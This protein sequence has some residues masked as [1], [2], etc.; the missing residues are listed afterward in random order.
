MPSCIYLNV[1]AVWI[2]FGELRAQSVSCVRLS[3]T[4]WTVAHQ[5]SLSMEFSRQE[6][7]SGLPFLSPRDLPDPGIEYASPALAGG[8]FTPETS[9]IQN[10]FTNKK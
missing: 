9:S 10:N 3:M 5:A 1:L 7:C 2:S 6:C 8:F 4:P